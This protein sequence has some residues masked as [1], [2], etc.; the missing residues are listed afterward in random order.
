MLQFNIN[1]NKEDFNGTF[2]KKE[3]TRYFS[4]I[5]AKLNIG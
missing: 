1:I 4:E 5:F 3:N 2:L